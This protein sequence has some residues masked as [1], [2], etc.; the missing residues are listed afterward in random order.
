MRALRVTFHVLL[1][2]CTSVRRQLAAQQAAPRRQ[3]TVDAGLLAA[4]LSYARV[5]GPEK[6]FGG[7]VGAGSEFNV[8]LVRGEPWGRKSADLLHVELFQR[9]EP[10]GRW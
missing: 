7:G 5:T 2:V 9:L 4:G 1:L 3:I 8:R 6:L 10:A